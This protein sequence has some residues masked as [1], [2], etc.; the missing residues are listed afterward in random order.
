MTE[1]TVRSADD[2]VQLL[3]GQ[4]NEIKRLFADALQ[5]SFFRTGSTAPKR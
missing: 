3:I 2:V 5:P 1:T 4:H